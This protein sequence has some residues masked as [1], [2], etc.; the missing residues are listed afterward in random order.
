MRNPPL[1]LTSILIASFFTVHSSFSQDPGSSNA[2]DATAFSPVG[3]SGRQRYLPVPGYFIPTGPM[4]LPGLQGPLPIAGYFMPTGFTGASSPILIQY[5]DTSIKYDE[6]NPL[7]LDYS[8]S[9]IY[10]KPTR[11]TKYARE[12]FQ[13]IENILKTYNSGPIS[14]SLK[15][16]YLNDE[17]I[18]EV[19]DFILSKEALKN[20]L[21]SLDLSNN[22]LTKDSLEILKRLLENCPNL[23]LDLSINLIS[24]KDLRSSF[25]ENLRSRITFSVA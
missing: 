24:S 12:V 20:N 1:Y 18:K 25:D 13:E 9:Q 16:N 15:E 22:R 19:H 17:G 8:A 21:T 6:S 14:L 23:K 11:S 7:D 4:G 2:E 3:S 10:H 5:P